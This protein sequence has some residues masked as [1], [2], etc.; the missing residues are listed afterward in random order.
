MTDRHDEGPGPPPLRVW[1][2]T[3]IILAMLSA[4][5]LAL[6]VLLDDPLRYLA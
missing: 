1:L 2:Y 5:G 6:F 4:I 3:A